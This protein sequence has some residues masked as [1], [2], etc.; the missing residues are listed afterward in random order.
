ASHLQNTQFFPFPLYGML[1]MTFNS[2]Y[3][4]RDSWWWY[5]LTGFDK[6][7]HIF[8]YPRIPD[9]SSAYHNTIF[10]ITVTIKQG[11]FRTVDIPI[12]KDR[13]MNSR[14]LFN[15]G[16]QFPVRFPF[17]HLLT[18]PSVNRDSFYPHILKSFSNLFYILG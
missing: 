5:M 1:D 12:P 11:F 10:T 18:S 15:L 16:Y 4:F 14:I 2:L 7:F 6:V 13:Y 8:K 9:C 17:I 3:S